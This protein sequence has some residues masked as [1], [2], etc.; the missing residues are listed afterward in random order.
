M[1]GREIIGP[2]VVVE[3]YWLDRASLPTKGDDWGA[4]DYDALLANE[5]VRDALDELR[6]KF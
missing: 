2:P 1:R 5:P 3:W 6:A 4:T